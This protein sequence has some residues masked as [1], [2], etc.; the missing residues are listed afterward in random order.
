MKGQIQLFRG[1][2]VV[3][4]VVVGV[5]W[6]VVHGELNRRNVQQWFSPQKVGAVPTARDKKQIG[7]GAGQGDLKSNQSNQ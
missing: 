5:V 6:A 2:V 4:V 1:P 7:D 3:V